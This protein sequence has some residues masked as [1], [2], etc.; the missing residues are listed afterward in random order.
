M[1]SPC[2]NNSQCV[3]E[4]GFRWTRFPNFTQVSFPAATYARPGM[5]TST[6]G[7]HLWTAVMGLFGPKAIPVVQSAALL[8]RSIQWQ[9]KTRRDWRRKPIISVLHSTDRWLYHQWVTV[10]SLKCLTQHIIHRVFSGN[11]L[12][13]K[14]TTKKQNGRRLKK[15]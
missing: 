3:A 4:C 2:N 14:L 10:T 7:T 15:K 13:T 12:R 6:R 5:T 11:Q 8:Q 9:M 1:L